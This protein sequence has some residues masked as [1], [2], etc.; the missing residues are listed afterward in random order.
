MSGHTGRMYSSPPGD[1][2]DQVRVLY[3]G[4]DDATAQQVYEALPDGAHQGVGPALVVRDED[5]GYVVLDPPRALPGGGTDGLVRIGPVDTPIGPTTIE[6]PAADLAH[7]LVAHHK[8]VHGL[9]IR[10]E[11]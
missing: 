1:R 5:G 8:A 4:P 9:P 3:Q 11:R 7:F 2:W 6:V 10:E